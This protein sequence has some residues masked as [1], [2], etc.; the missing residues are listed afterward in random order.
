MGKKETVRKAKQRLLDAMSKVD[1]TSDA[2]AQ[3]N[4]QLE[5]LTKSEFNEKGWRSQLGIGLAQTAISTVTSTVQ[6]WSVLK[7]EDR[8]NIVNTRSLNYVQKPIVNNVS[9]VKPK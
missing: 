8:G 2:Y 4:G 3:L 1:P 6:V 7:H 9:N 5:K